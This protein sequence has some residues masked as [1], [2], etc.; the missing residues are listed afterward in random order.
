MRVV[1]RGEAA[2]GA[3]VGAAAEQ[4]RRV[5]RSR[6][7]A[8][9]SDKRVTD[10]V[11]GVFSAGALLGLSVLSGVAGAAADAARGWPGTRHEGAI[12]SSSRRVSVRGW[13]PESSPACTSASSRCWGRVWLMCD[14]WE[15][16]V[17]G[18]R[19]SGGARRSVS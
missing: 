6:G 1:V 17:Q 11:A 2:D 8:E 5:S 15:N 7:C 4:V 3:A 14:W 19:A 12:S 16:Q 18:C 13:M 10:L 9:A